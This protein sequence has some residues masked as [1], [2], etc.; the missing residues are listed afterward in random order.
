MG[1]VELTGLEIMATNALGQLRAT[2][3]TGRQHQL[4]RNNTCQGTT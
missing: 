1:T 2:Y 4:T 3:K